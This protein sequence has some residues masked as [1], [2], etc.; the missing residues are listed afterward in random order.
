[1]NT[2]IK[3]TKKNNIK[4]PKKSIEYN[5]IK[6]LINILDLFTKYN[7]DEKTTNLIKKKYNIKNKSSEIINKNEFNLLSNFLLKNDEILPFINN[8]IKE[9][10]EGNIILYGYK[11]CLLNNNFIDIELNEFI[12][13]TKNENLYNIDNTELKIIIKRFQYYE[14]KFEDRFIYIGTIIFIHKNKEINRLPIYGDV[15]QNLYIYTERTI[16]KKYYSFINISKGFIF[17]EYDKV[18][19]NGMIYFYYNNDIIKYKFDNELLIYE[20]FDSYFN[21]QYLNDLKYIEEN[22]DL[23]FIS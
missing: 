13:N 15:F 6:T 3:K 14:K 18:I 23:S 22:A 17:Y 4:I 16:Y 1:M 2:I 19:N 8:N 12:E 20:D 5:R 7:L 21:I 10:R 11:R 9:S